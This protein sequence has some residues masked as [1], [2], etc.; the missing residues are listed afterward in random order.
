MFEVKRGTSVFILRNH[1][2][3]F[4]GWNID[5]GNIMEEAMIYE[6]VTGNRT[7]LSQEPIENVPVKNR[8]NV[9]LI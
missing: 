9:V 3:T 4:L 6:E 5:P 7:S 2:E 1:N 8:E